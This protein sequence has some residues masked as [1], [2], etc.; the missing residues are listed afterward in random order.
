[1]RR[2]SGTFAAVGAAFAAGVVVGPMVAAW[3]QDG[4]RA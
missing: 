2:R 4:S 3:A 1:M